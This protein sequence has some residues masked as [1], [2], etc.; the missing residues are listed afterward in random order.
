MVSVTG[1]VGFVGL[2]VGAYEYVFVCVSVWRVICVSFCE[3]V[4]VC[5]CLFMCVC[6]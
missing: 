3:F 6:V 1:C 5:V 4:Y 2:S